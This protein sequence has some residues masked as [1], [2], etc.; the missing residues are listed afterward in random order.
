MWNNKKIWLM[1]F[2]ELEKIEDQL[3]HHIH[4]NVKIVR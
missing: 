4:M 2:I 3:H 1:D